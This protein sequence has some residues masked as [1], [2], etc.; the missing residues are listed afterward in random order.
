MWMQGED[1]N[2]VDMGLKGLIK[3]ASEETLTSTQSKKIIFNLSEIYL[4]SK[5]KKS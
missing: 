4:G 1:Q 2:V 5:R 3:L